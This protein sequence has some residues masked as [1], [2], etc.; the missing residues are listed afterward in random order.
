[1]EPA[2]C[3]MCSSD[4]VWQMEDRVKIGK[5]VFIERIEV[6]GSNCGWNGEK[7]YFPC[8]DSS[9]I[10]VYQVTGEQIDNALANAKPY[11][12]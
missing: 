7:A 3:P 10:I 2:I 8:F 12:E 4:I 6:C 9:E 1:M 5:H 11:G